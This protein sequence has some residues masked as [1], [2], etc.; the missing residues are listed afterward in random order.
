M[1]PNILVAWYSDDRVE[2]NLKDW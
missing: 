2:W 1:S